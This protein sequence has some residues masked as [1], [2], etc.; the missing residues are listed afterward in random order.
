MVFIFQYIPALK[1]NHLDL[2]DVY[3]GWIFRFFLYSEARMLRNFVFALGQAHFS[4]NT[5]LCQSDETNVCSDQIHGIFAHRSNRLVY[6]PRLGNSQL[7]IVLFFQ[8]WF[9]A[10]RHARRL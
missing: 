3:A 6:T 10:R 2:L 8:E 5:V 4:S 7:H 1:W 9:R